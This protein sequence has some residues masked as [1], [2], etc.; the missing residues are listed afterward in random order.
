MIA[1]TMAMARATSTATTNGS[2]FVIEIAKPYA[3]SSRNA[4]WPC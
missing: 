1:N 3:P 4:A 2:P